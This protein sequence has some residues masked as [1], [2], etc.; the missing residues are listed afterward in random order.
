MPNP[1]TS[2]RHGFGLLLTPRNPECTVSPQHTPRGDPYTWEP[3]KDGVG[4]PV[5]LIVGTKFPLIQPL[6]ICPSSSITV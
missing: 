4:V 5:H 2:Y 1:L 3:V 6:V